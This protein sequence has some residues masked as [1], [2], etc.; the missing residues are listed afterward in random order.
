MLWTAQ[1][2]I[3]FNVLISLFR[4][5]VPWDGLVLNAARRCWIFCF[6][7]LCCASSL[8]RLLLTLWEREVL[9]HSLSH[10]SDANSVD[11]HQVEACT[12]ERWYQGHFY[13]LYIIW[14][15]LCS[16]WT[17]WCRRHWFWAVSWSEP[18]AGCP[19]Y[20]VSLGVTAE[21]SPC[22]KR[23]WLV[24]ETELNQPE[25]S[26]FSTSKVFL[27]LLIILVCLHVMGESC[28]P[29]WCVLCVCHWLMKYL[30]GSLF[31][32]KWSHGIW[33]LCS[34][35]TLKGASLEHQLDAWAYLLSLYAGKSAGLGLC[36]GA[37][38]CL[39]RKC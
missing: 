4:D 29:G 15:S 18:F 33:I 9:F 30:F 27:P 26:M 37:D 14:G 8:S 12:E 3:K 24:A 28:L 21:L 11:Q 7:A 2:E 22:F 5:C 35:G 13:P 10:S 34:P 1:W 17:C 19:V 6:S 25:W 31:P 23:C 36:S 20:W 38:S 16:F 39:G 32:S